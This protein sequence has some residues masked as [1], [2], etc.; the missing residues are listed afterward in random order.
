MRESVA[1][2][3][4]SIADCDVLLLLLG[5]GMSVDSGLAAYKDVADFAPYKEL[6]V[7]YDDLC[8]PHHLDG[9]LEGVAL[10][11]GFWGSCFNA[12]RAARPHEGYDICRAWKRRAPECHVY[13]SNVD[14][15]VRRS[16]LASSCSDLYELHGNCEQWQCAAKCRDKLWRAP[17]D[18]VFDVDPQTMLARP[19]VI[20][21]R[22]GAG[23]QDDFAGDEMFES[24]EV[25]RQSFATAFPSCPFCGGHARPAV[26]MFDDFKWVEN[27]PHALG[28]DSLCERLFEDGP[29]DKRVTI[30][31]IGCGK[32]VPCVRI[33]SEDLI[34]ELVQQHKAPEPLLVRINPDFPLADRED[35]SPW[36]ASL[37]M[38]A[39]AALRMLDKAM[40]ERDRTDKMN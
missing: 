3:A 4:R 21:V 24:S 8:R 10:F 27:K 20:G 1:R 33:R 6:D 31:E 15:L 9:S 17:A 28:Y 29:R 2:A 19:A 32:T 7:D 35:L 39:L 40:E 16:D 25:S 5:A 14:S 11:F 36:V 34:T 26:L 22:K 30:V 37:P 38:G 23:G 18:Y 13:T 12:Y